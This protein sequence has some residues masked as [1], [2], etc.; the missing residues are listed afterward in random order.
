[1]SLDPNAYGFLKKY[2]LDGIGYD[3][4]A[5]KEYL[6]EARLTPI[7]PL[8]GCTDASSLIQKLQSQ[9]TAALRQAIID[10]M[11]TNESL[12]FRDDVPFQYLRNDA[13]PRLVRARAATRTLRIWSA[14]CSTGQEPYSIA[15]ILREE[16]A[17]LG[18]TGWKIELLAS[19]ISTNALNKAKAGIFSNFEV[20]RGLP[21]ATRNTYFEQIQQGWRFKQELV[22]PVRFQQHNLLDPPPPMGPFDLIFL[23]NVLIYFEPDLK[24]RA[25]GRMA[26]ALAPDGCL[27]LGA[28]ECILDSTIPLVR[29]EGVGS[30]I[31]RRKETTH[32]AQLR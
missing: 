8:H 5:G 13:L 15:I 9:P 4:G 31:Y 26:Q 6:V 23:R 11:V 10:S 19:D 32:A 16:A 27:F 22:T 18:I 29:I 12:F 30:S 1:M 14:A 24:S 7:A 21:E 28:A 17:R 25:L 3:M 20:Q 2:L